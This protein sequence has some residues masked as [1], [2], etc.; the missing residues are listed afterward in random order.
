MADSIKA[1]HYTYPDPDHYQYP[2]A[3]RT[4]FI[5]ASVRSGFLLWEFSRRFQIF[6]PLFS[7]AQHTVLKLVDLVS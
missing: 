7:S 3:I 1:Y 5:L 2:F 6:L 4:T